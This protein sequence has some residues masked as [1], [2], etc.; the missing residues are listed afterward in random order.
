[1]STN[2]KTPPSLSKCTSYETWL[3]EIQIWQTF[4]DLEPKKQGP[5]IF[6]TLEGQAREAVLELDVAN[7]SA[8]DGVDQIITKLNGL[9]LKDKTQSAFEAYDTFEKFRRSKEMSM[10]DYIN[11]FERLKSKIENYKMSLSTDIMAYRLLKS[12]NL[13]EA[14]EQLAKATIPSLTYEDMKMQ[15]KKKFGDVTQNKFDASDL[16]AIKSESSFYQSNARGNNFNRYKKK[17]NRPWENKKKG[18]QNRDQTRVKSPKQG[19]NPLN[20]KGEV[21]RCDICDSINHWASNCPDA[22]YYQDHSD[23]SDDSSVDTHQIT[24]FQSSLVMSD[25]FNVFVT[26][27]LNTAVL[28]SGATTNVAGK[29]WMKCYLDSLSEGDKAQVTQS[30][31]GNSFK[32]GSDHIFCSLHKVKFPATIGKNKIFIETDVIDTN[33]PLLLSKRAMKTADT[34]IN[35]VNDTVEMFGEKQEVILT[36]S[37]HY[38]VPLDNKKKIL[39]DAASNTIKIVLHVTKGNTDKNKMASKLHSQFAHPTPEKLIKLVSAAGLGNDLEL[40]N[41]IK[42]ISRKCG[43]CSVYRKSSVKPIVSMPLAADFNEVVALDLKFYNGKI[44]LHLIDHVSRFSAAAVVKSKKPNEIIAKIFRCWISLFGPPKRYFHDNG[45]EFVNAEFLELCDSFNIVVLTTAAESPWSNGLCERHNA[46]LSDMLDKIIEERQCDLEIALCWAIHAKNSLSNVH[47]FSPYQ[48][49]IGYTPKMPCVLEASPPA[50]ETTS[51]DIVLRNLKA[52]ESS[53]KA[54]IEAE[55]KEKIKRA[56]KSNLRTS[57]NQKY[58]SGDIVFYKRNDS[59][60]WKGP[61]KVLGTDSQQVLLKHGGIYVRVHKCRLMLAEDSQVSV[62]REKDEDLVLTE[63]PNE[64]TMRSDS[65][66]EAQKNDSEDN[67]AIG[68][69]VDAT[70]NKNVDTDSDE[71]ADLSFKDCTIE[72]PNSGLSLADNCCSNTITELPKLKKGMKID[73][74]ESDSDEW[75]TATVISRAGKVSGIYKNSWNIKDDTGNFVEINT[76]NVQWQPSNANVASSDSEMNLGETYLTEVETATNEAKSRELE[77]WIRED[78]YQEV[79]DVGQETITVRWVITPKLVDGVMTTKARLVARGF[80]EDSA[81]LRT[82]SPTCMKESLRLLLSIASSKSWRINS[83]DIKV[84]FLQGKEIN[85]EVYLKPPK[86]ADSNNKL[87]KLKK[88]VYGLT[89][90]SRVWYL[91]VVDELDKLGASISQY[92][93]AFFTWKSGKTLQGLIAMHVDDF[94]W[95]GTDQ[96]ENTIINSVRT[97]FKVSKESKKAFRY[98]GVDLRQ[99][100]GTL[101]LDQNNYVESIQPV[102]IP[103]AIDRNLE[104]DPTLRTSYKALIGQISWACITS[105]PDVCYDS[106]YLSTQQAM[107]TYKSLNDAN[108]ALRELKINKSGLKFPKLDL[109]SVT[110]A[111]FCDAS[112]GNLPD[113]KSQGGHI[114]FLKDCEG[115]CSPI[116]WSSRRLKRVAR[117]TLSAE[118]IAAVEAV[119]SAYMVS[120]MFAEIFS[121]PTSREIEIYTDNKSLYDIVRTTNVPDDKRLRIDVASLREAQDKDR[122][123]FN[124]ISSEKQ[125][126]DALTKKGASKKLLRGVLE[127]ARLED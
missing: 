37:G 80:Q 46:V 121:E 72:S 65:E 9:F 56:L 42:Y 95:C 122:V 23:S 60:R 124:W 22:V 55:S 17:P 64:F 67:A 73:Y 110:F 126:A 81:D 16:G 106:C 115:N 66:H 89:D 15:L 45:G 52:I 12:A 84:A 112:Y 98:L 118:T 31:S 109:T 48:I 58:V 2:I 94:I 83:I 102:L 105:R 91:R 82:D 62:Q 116:S 93:K 97:T 54:F 79:E 57:N 27:T 113:G 68:D 8:S 107:P 123:I 21:S 25:Q 11:E 96:F 117:S 49:A 32:F 13:S 88:A 61:A 103:N 7:I 120:N 74:K 34:Q 75:K 41:A 20:K 69:E 33:L 104:V 39:E 85:R 1:M 70:H 10:P 28:D 24:L 100:R 26:E 77:S 5:A 53:R 90:A 125:I 101:L 43:V 92:D 63:K 76:E 40:I 6:L 29:T 86:E 18:W 14:H 114:I 3:K 50:L 127:S 38:S 87:W 19:R 44:I 119:D 59:K 108:K 35:F 36:R 30:D 71:D 4:T 111:V 47:G 78:V 99:N 51:N